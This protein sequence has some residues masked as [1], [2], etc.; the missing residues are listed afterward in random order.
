MYIIFGIKYSFS[1]Q[2]RCSNQVM[3][4]DIHPD[5]PNMIA[6]GLYDGNVAVS[7]Q[8]LCEKK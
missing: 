4:L 6:V 3:C 5:Y 8:D 1:K 7:E 2:L